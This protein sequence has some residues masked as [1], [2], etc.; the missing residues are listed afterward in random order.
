ML[1]DCERTHSDIRKPD[2][3]LFRIVDI[4]TQV[5]FTAPKR[6]KKRLFEIEAACQEIAG[7]WNDQPVKEA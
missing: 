6:T 5:I 3:N 7:G 1:H 4:S 2:P